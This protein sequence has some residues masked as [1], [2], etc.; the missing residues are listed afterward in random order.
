MNIRI[1]IGADHRGFVLKSFLTTKKMVGPFSIEWEDV[2]TCT[3]ERTDYPLFARK[4]VQLMQDCWVDVGIMACGTGIG[5]AIAAN[6]FRGIYAGLAWNEEVGRK[7]KEDDNVNV[8]VL[9]A[10]FI[11]LQEGYDIVLAWLSASFKAGRYQERLTLLDDFQRESCL[12]L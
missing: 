2:G 10:D 8:L 12:S 9:P 3:I 7:A 6:R 1:A 11:S 5:M 4:V